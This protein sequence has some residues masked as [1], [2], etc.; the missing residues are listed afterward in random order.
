MKRLSFR[1]FFEGTDLFGF[2]A[3]R[4]PIE[5]ED[6]M[7]SKP[8]NQFNLELMIEL[9]EKKKIGKQKGSTF[10]VNEIS[11]GNQPGA[12]RLF[13]DT[14][15]TFYL[16]KLN[17]DKLGENCWATKRMF[18]LNRL[19]YGGLEDAVS[20]EIHEQ[21]Q[22]IYE[23]PLDNP[24]DDYDDLENLVFQM[25]DR[26]QKVMKDIFIPQGIRKID[27]YN[28]I[29]RCGVRGGGVQEM[30]QRR[31]EQNQTLVSYNKNKG[32]ISISNYNLT[33]KVGGPHSWDIGHKDLD[34]KCFPSQS[35]EEIA[36]LLAVNLKYY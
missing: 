28:Y 32:V 22:K 3:D 13:V 14:G 2:D 36:E 26:S 16:Q 10:F 4:S 7:L 9:L 19:G 12:V 25:A 27:D 5:R 20:H 1:R 8:I 17:K 24:V 15:L 21:L 33:S 30:D 29:I 34:I 35:R 18:Q 31:V 23:G 6:N 11:W